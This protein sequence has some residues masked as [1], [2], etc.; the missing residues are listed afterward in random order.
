MTRNGYNPL[1]PLR[2][3]DLEQFNQVRNPPLVGDVYRITTTLPAGRTGRHL[4]YTIW[5]RQLP[6]STE[7]F[8]LCNDVIF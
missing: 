7:A 4:I 3:S 8:Y 5:Q 2:W 1:T 6:D